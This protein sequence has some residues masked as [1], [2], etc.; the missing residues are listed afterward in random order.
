MIFAIALVFFANP[1]QIDSLPPYFVKVIQPRTL[2]AQ[3]EPVWVIL[4]IGNQSERTLKTKKLPKI[5][6]NLIVEQEEQTLPLASDFSTKTLFAKIAS[7]DMGF[8]R[9]FRLDL[10]KYFPTLKIDQPFSV[11]YKDD[12]YNLTGKNMKIEPVDL[13]PLDATYLVKTSKGEFGIKLDPDQAPQH[14]R[15]FAILVASKYYKDMVF[16]RV[17]KDYVIQS[18]DPLG[19]GAGGSDYTMDLEKSPL[20]KHT[21]YAVGMA[22]MPQSADSASSQFYVCLKRLEALDGGYTVFGKAISGFDVIQAIGDVATTGLDGTPPE[23]PLF[24]VQ[25]QGIE[26]LLDSEN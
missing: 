10:R 19:T 16:H 3:D 22:R 25:L 5:L 7:I 13:P 15:N 26:I 12:I 4:R 20:L 21:Q 8:H 23:K 18:G 6:E 14:S 2:F 9:D 1:T 11:R 24:D 17:I